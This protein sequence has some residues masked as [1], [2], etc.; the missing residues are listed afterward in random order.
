MQAWADEYGPI[1]HIRL[2]T[3]HVGAELQPST[4]LAI[5]E[6]RL[7]F[8]PCLASMKPYAFADSGGNRSQGGNRA[9]AHA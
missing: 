4:L 3:A 6:L 1:Y 8:H 7:H 2:L 9:L 5:L